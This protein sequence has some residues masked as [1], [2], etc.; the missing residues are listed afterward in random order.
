MQKTD[1]GLI[2]AMKVLPVMSEQNCTRNKC[3]RF[4]LETWAQLLM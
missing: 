3:L 1:C 2:K 4:S